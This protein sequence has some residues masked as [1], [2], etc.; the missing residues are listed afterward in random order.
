MSLEFDLSTQLVIG[1]IL[2]RW[3][4]KTPG[5]EA[6]VFKNQR[7]T[8]GAFNTR[9]NRLA[10]ALVKL[11]IAKGDKVAVLF[12]NCIEI[13]ECYMAVCKI[14]AVV[15]SINFRLVDREISYQLD[16]SDAKAVIYSGTFHNIISSLRDQQ[17][18]VAHYICHSEKEIKEAIQYD[19]LLAK[20]SP[21]EP[22][23]Y[24]Q[25]DDPAFIMYTSGTTGKPKGAVITHKNLLVEVTNILLEN[26]IKKGDRSLFSAPLFHVAALVHMLL[27]FYLG[28]RSVIMDKFEPR[29]FLRLVEKEKITVGMLIPAMWIFLLQEPGISEY[30]TRTL[31]NVGTGGAVL[32][33]EV[34]R[35]AMDAFPNVGIYNI[36]G[37]TETSSCTTLLYPEHAF[38]KEGSVGRRIV[39]LEARIVDV[40]DNDV[41]VGQVGEIIY[42]GPTIMK[43]YY[44]NPQ[45][46]ADAIREGWFH[47]GDL[48]RE[49]EDGFIWVVD[50]KKDMIISGGENIYPAE[51]E[52]VLFSHP[53]IVEAAVI[54]VP[55]PQ[56]GESV[57][58]IVV[59][60]KGE[61]L[62]AEE[63]IEH[64]KT[65][66]A[67][68]K[69]PKTVE[70][71]AELPRN[72]AGKVR[73]FELRD[74]YAS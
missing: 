71:V 51:V 52:E 69:K 56:W 5:N 41:A 44:N 55:D 6:F 74:K 62:T 28:G 14:G 4:R 26:D 72:A 45:A 20:S 1:E 36:F 33:V 63:I 59:P 8:F 61:T 13:L 49:D 15:V 27:I 37:Q 66:M 11:G 25:D 57:K 67:S 12:M 58:A 35:K 34:M 38:S 9:V 48:V 50:R 39:N 30:D 2:A 42:R 19:A 60:Q 16:Q 24:V 40:A 21:Q 32:P 29:D 7:V 3:A 73:K 10:N 68:Y 47:S 31:R 70:F 65:H 18:K 17:P 22:L 64:C 54:G 23:V 46:T 43:E 53:K